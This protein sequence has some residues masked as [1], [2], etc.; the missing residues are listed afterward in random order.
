MR[1]L[2]W[3]SAAVVLFACGPI[4]GIDTK[5]TPTQQNGG[6]FCVP[7]A[8]APAGQALKLEIWDICQGGCGAELKL[9]CT[10]TR[11]AGTLT[12]SL[13]GDVCRPTAPM[14]CPAVCKSES[15]LCDVPPLPEGDY[16]VFSPSQTS[17]VLQVRD[18]GAT[19][20][21]ALPF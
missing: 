21:D 7:D 13:T 8:G 2:L 20:C 10:V 17:K 9:K 5:C 12:L 18:A 4:P 3:V 16:T 11:D 19:T 6:P 1:A 15:F 14:A